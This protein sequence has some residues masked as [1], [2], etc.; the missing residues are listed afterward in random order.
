MPVRGETGRL[1]PGGGG[2]G[3]PVI[4]E[5]APR[6]CGGDATAPLSGPGPPNIG[7]A[8]AAPLA[9]APWP[10]C[11]AAPERAVIAAFATATAGWA[12]WAEG[13]A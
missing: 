2:I 1:K 7:L 13:C 5:T 4:G 9:W 11:D 8:G 6:P 12:G 3:L 10:A